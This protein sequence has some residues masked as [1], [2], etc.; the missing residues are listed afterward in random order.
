MLKNYLLLIA[1]LFV[2]QFA[3]GQNSIYGDY[4]GKQVIFDTILYTFHLSLKEDGRCTMQYRRMDSV[5]TLTGKW[6]QKGDKIKL[7]HAYS[8]ADKAYGLERTASLNIEGD[9]LI[10]KPTQNKR[11]LEK[12]KRKAEREVRKTVGEKVTL[13]IVMAEPLVL[14][15]EN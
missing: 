7:R 5:V 15:K 10:W 2:V 13:T 3:V 6:W 8:K 12:G 11:K 4:K 1:F 9:K 14:I